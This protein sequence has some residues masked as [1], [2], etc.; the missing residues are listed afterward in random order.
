MKTDIL[1][2]ALFFLIGLISGAVVAGI[3]IYKYLNSQEVYEEPE[4][5]DNDDIPKEV[6]N[7]LEGIFGKGNVKVIKKVNP[8]EMAQ[9]IQNSQLIT[10]STVFSTI[11]NKKNF[12]KDLEA[13][14][15]KVVTDG[16][17]DYEKATHLRD[18]I[19]TLSDEKQDWFD[20]RKKWFL[21]HIGQRVKP[22]IAECPCGG[23]EMAV[24]NGLVIQDE[25]QALSLFAQENRSKVNQ[26]EL[27]YSE[28]E[29]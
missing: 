15:H 17:E 3:V 28:Y 19:S 26:G 29:G 14:L 21:D 11:T 18:L 4:H 24:E 5:N 27:R 2:S 13:R 20:M 8:F 16:S 9:E 10:P 6:S 12:K 23:C 22:N 7:M 25:N 1:L